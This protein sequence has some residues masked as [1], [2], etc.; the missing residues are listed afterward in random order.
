MKNNVNKIIKMKINKDVFNV[1]YTR[2]QGA[3]GQHKNKT[4]TCVVITHIPSGLQE[5]CEDQRSRNQN[6]KIAYSRLVKKIVA[7]TK[8]KQHQQ[9]VEKKNEMMEKAGRIR[10]YNYQRNEVKDHRSGKT[11]PL[12]KVLNGNIDLLK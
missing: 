5:R 6:E 10:T 3:G 11:A 2:G 12:N 4:E 8:Q 1:E 7:L 9:L